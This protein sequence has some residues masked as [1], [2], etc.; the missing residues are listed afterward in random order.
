MATILKACG[1]RWVTPKDVTVWLADSYLDLRAQHP[2]ALRRA[3][4][5]GLVRVT[6]EQGDL[7]E[8]IVVVDNE[9]TEARR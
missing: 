8:L 3:E 6:R 1:R 9:V 7:H 4:R 5:A 2:D